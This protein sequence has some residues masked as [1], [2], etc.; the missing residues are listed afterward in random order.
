[1]KRLNVEVVVG[2]FMLIG[3][4]SLAYVTFTL[5]GENFS[6]TNRYRLTAQFSS[7]TGVKDGAEVEVAGVP[8]GSVVDV[9]LDPES[10]NA[11]LTMEIDS[12]VQLQEDSIAGVKSASLLGGKL[13]G[14]S[15]GGSDVILE[16][17]DEIIDTTPSVS[18]E[19]L[20]GKYIFDG[21]SE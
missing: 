19:E 7:I 17:G 13:I 6:T 10:Y 1:M 3:F 9:S 18:L 8:V 2:L 21:G 11:V 14:I 5:G 12:S 4:L 15:P 16:D 20:I